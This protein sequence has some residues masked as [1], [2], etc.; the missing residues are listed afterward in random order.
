M[1]VVTAWAKGLYTSAQKKRPEHTSEDVDAI[2]KAN[3]EQ[4]HTYSNNSLATLVTAW[5]K[6]N[7]VVSLTVEVASFFHKPDVQQ[8][9]ATLRVGTHKVVW[10]PA[11]AQRSHKRASGNM[12]HTWSLSN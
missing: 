4:T 9:N 12:K 6:V 11:F 5:S 2:L 10:A 8:L 7:G 3:K 1:H